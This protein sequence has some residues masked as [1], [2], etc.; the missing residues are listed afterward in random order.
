MPLIPFAPQNQPIIQREAPLHLNE[1]QMGRSIQH[2]G[3]PTFL[4][5]LR[6]IRDDLPE[7]DTD[8][9]IITN[10]HD[11]LSRIPRNEYDGANYQQELSEHR[12]DLSRDIKNAIANFLSECHEA[13]IPRKECRAQ[14]AHET[15]IKGRKLASQA[16]RMGPDGPDPVHPMTPDGIEREAEIY[17]EKREESWIKSKI[18]SKNL[19][20][21]QEML[22]HIVKNLSKDWSELSIRL[23]NDKLEIMKDAKNRHP[24]IAHDI[25]LT[26]KILELE[27]ENSDAQ[28][29]LENPERMIAGDRL[30]HAIDRVIAGRVPLL[31]LAE[32]P[33]SVA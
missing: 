31:L 14:A 23:S 25:D 26:S 10:Y 20:A 18:G 32:I 13:K 7:Y 33:Q 6:N 1:I 29:F 11:I 22:E 24:E 17:R 3:N 28:F 27:D 9:I 4:S 21:A 2:V 12:E 30:K 5:D 16:N 15:L 8:E 19:N